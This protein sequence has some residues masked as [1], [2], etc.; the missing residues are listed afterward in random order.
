MSSRSA[1]R[2]RLVLGASGYI[3]THLVPRLLDAG[4]PVR[5]SSRQPGV[6]AARGWQGVEVVA[7]D[8]LDPATLPAALVGFGIACYLVHSIGAGRDFG[9]LDLQAAAKAGVE[10]I[11]QG[12]T[13]EIARRAE[14]QERSVRR[15]P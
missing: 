14:A 13:R 8:A 10:L 5:V 7:A 12:L 2:R 11:F 4:V 6:L 15:R 1:S 9:R 3:G